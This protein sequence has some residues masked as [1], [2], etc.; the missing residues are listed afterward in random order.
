LNISLNGDGS[1]LNVVTP[2]RTGENYIDNLT[3][4]LYV[5]S[6]ETSADWVGPFVYEAPL[7]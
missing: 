5:S 1:P 3:G 7:E 2:D 6:G 4:D